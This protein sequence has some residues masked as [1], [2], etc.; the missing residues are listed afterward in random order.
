MN[1]PDAMLMDIGNVLLKVDIS[2][3][4]SVLHKHGLTIRQDVAKQFHTL[5]GKYET[6]D[7]T[8]ESFLE[9]ACLLTGLPYPEKKEV[10]QEAWEAVFPADSPIGTTIDTCRQLKEKGIRLILFSNT[11]ELHVRYM[12]THYPELRTLFDEAI[13]SHITG[14]EKP[15]PPMY[16]EARDILGL[17]P[18]RTLYFDDKPENIQAGLNFGFQAH[19]FD[20]A[21]PET[22]LNVLPASWKE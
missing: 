6:G 21:R 10:L 12:D 11:N 15:A 3:V 18:A 8:T 9:Q 7:V 16:L 19:V 14:A 20:Y 4:S 2:G 17:D 5:A 22:F 13:Y 1:T